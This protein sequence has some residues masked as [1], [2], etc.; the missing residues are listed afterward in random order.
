MKIPT[1]YIPPAITKAIAMVK[2]YR[3]S[4]RKEKRK[5][6]SINKKIRKNAKNAGSDHRFLMHQSFPYVRIAPM[7]K[8]K[9]A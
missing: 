4:V 6:D 7:I 2:S 3:K 1:Y 5:A 9:T 8:Y